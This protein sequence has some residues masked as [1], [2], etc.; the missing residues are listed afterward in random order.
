MGVP[1]GWLKGDEKG[2]GDEGVGLGFE[3]THNGEPQEFQ[4]GK[5]ILRSPVR[6]QFPNRQ[7]SG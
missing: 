1:L 6:D 4:G 3:V 5:R 2:F 7:T